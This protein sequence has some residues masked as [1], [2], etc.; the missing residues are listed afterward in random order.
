MKLILILFGETLGVDN[1]DEYM[2]TQ[3]VPGHKGYFRRVLI[4]DYHHM[5]PEKMPAIVKKMTVEIQYKFKGKT[6]TVALP[7]IITK[8]D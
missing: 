3:E 2:P 5:H 7:T 1:I 4:E 6:E 8:N